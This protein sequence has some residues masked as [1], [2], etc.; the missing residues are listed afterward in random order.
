MSN[1]VDFTGQVV[2]DPNMAD[3]D[4]NK[5]VWKTNI[6]NDPTRGKKKKKKKK[7]PKEDDWAKVE[8]PPKK[9]HYQPA[10]ETKK[11]PK[12]KK[13]KKQS[14]DGKNST[15]NNNKS[16]DDS[17][18]K[19]RIVRVG[20]KT[21]EIED[22]S[23]TLLLIW[24]LLLAKLFLDLVTSTI[25]F[26]AFLQ[27]P[28]DCC[29]TPISTGA[30]PLG[31][32]IPFFLLVLLELVLLLRSVMLTL[33]PHMLM[34]EAD[35]ESGSKEKCNIF[36]WNSKFCVWL[37]NTLTVINP[38]LGFGIAWMLMYQ[39]D[40]VEALTVM[41]LELA[42]IILHFGSVHLEKAARTIPLKLMHGSIILP[43]LAT[44]SINLWYINQGGVCYDTSLETFW[45]KGC[46][47]CPSGIRPVNDTLCPT[48]TLVNGTN[49]TTYDAI[50]LWELGS[51]TSC[52]A[53]TEVC[54]FEY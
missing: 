12:K 6:I 43:W 1:R 11:K 5:A 46:E 18:P 36:S 28:P 21:Y 38:Y 35:L 33:F 13:D 19:K 26:I 30:Y 29:E 52:E 14:S 31:I 47:I 4:D 34:S 23:K 42:T 2:K 45:Y 10:S 41:G 27:V 15:K 53:G 54:W 3:N 24:I 25:A 37:V 48:T 32:T 7:K 8:I 49:V 22:P 39:S 20:H 9:N 40:K 16:S 44:L 17:A 50:P 51:A